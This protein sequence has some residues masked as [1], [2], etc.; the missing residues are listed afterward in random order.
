MSEIAVVE[1]RILL[2]P[3]RAYQLSRLAQAKA[4][5]EDK[6]VEKALDILFGVTDLLDDQAERRGWSLVAERSLRRV[7]DN[8]QDAE[9]DNWRELYDIPAR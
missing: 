1:K 6:I 4:I 5:S 3:E 8:E 7:W 9:Y 2:S